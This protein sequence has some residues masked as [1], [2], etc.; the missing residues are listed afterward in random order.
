MMIALHSRLRQPGVPGRMGSDT[1]TRFLDAGTQL[2]RQQGYTATGVKQLVELGGAPLGSLYHFFPGGKE[3]IAL[4]GIERAA[5][6]YEVLLERVLA[7]YPDVGAAAL[8]W[9]SMAAAALRESDF[10]DGCPIGTLTGEVAVSHDA[11][12]EAGH[13]VFAAW[14][15]RVAARLK[16]AGLTARE[17]RRLATFSVAA[18]EGAI[19]LARAQRSTN[20][21]TETGRVVAETLRRAVDTRD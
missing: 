14:Q 11:L 19:L 15:R 6:R 3:Q 4:E 7:R 5:Q 1:R 10:R 8:A 21:L 20:P 17:A 13:A 12:R 2:F 18:L 9:F 16:E